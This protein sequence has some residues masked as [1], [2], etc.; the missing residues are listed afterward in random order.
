MIRICKNC[1]KSFEIGTQTNKLYCC[2]KCKIEYNS[3]KYNKKNKERIKVTF[4]KWR[5]E[6]RERFNELANK[7]TK[8]YNKRVYRLRKE[9]GLC[10]ICGKKSDSEK[11]TCS[12]CLK[13]FKERY[14]KQ[15]QA[16]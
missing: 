7:A 8:K 6:N 13:N 10:P 14:R 11:I 9:N 15:K 2:Y 1:K 3:K 12:K 16:N 4:D 5:K